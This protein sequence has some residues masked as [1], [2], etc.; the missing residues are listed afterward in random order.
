MTGPASQSHTS[1]G[2]VAS[3]SEPPGPRPLGLLPELGLDPALRLHVS[4]LVLRF[5][6]FMS[7]LR[8]PSALTIRGPGPQRSQ[9]PGCPDS[10]PTSAARARRR[11][12]TERQRAREAAHAHTRP[13]AARTAPLP[14]TVGGTCRPEPDQDRDTA[15]GHPLHRPPVGPTGPQRGQSAAQAPTKC[16]HCVLSPMPS[17]PRRRQPLTDSDAWSWPGISHE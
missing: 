16:R 3:S 12:A 5:V 9:Y 6:R 1:H 15:S 14:A 13:R 4:G 17:V 7:L 10:A 2:P 11:T 8:D